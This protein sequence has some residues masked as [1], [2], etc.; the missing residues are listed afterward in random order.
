MIIPDKK[1][2][3]TVIMSRMG[4]GAS[5]KSQEIKNEVPID[6]KMGSLKAIAEDMI[7]AFHDKSPM[8]LVDSLQAFLREYENQESSNT[9]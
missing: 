1:K 9:D 4:Q 6:E 8:A 7:Q 3:L 5:D 2:A